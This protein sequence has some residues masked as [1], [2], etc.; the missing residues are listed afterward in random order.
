MLTVH[1]K[2]GRER[3]LENR[4]P[5][6]FDGAIA[7]VQ[8]EPQPGDLVDVVD[9]AGAFRGRGY[10]N[11]HSQ[12][13]VRILTW[14]RDEMIDAAFWRRRLAASIARRQMLPSLESCTAYRLVYA[15]SDGL[16]GLIVD[17]YGDWL[18][19]QSLTAG[20][21]R[22]KD[23]L[24]RLLVELLEPKG[25]Y[26]RSDADVRPREGLAD[27]VGVL[28]GEAPQSDPPGGASAP[29]RIGENGRRFIV[30]IAQGHKTGFYLDQRDNRERVARY[31]EGA[32]VLNAFAYTG[33]FGV[34]AGTAGASRVTNLDSSAEALALAA[35][36]MALNGIA[37]DR[38]ESIQGDAFAILRTM[39]DQ[40]RR[41]DVIV[42]DPPKFAFSR[43][44]VRSA[45][46][47]YKDI[48][49]QA[50]H[51]L[52]PGGILVTFSCSGAVDETLFQKV[53]FG[54]S[55]DAGRD[56]SILERLSQAS[57]HPVLLTFPEGA[58]LKGFVCQVR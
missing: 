35:E 21:E 40:A 15:E 19:L 10:Y 44:Q 32:E 37:A 8:G 1:L 48:N 51:L 49:L 6:I 50:M 56:V 26:E 29:V 43:A 12:I 9:S 20:I 25:V 13:T 24:A 33:G 42:L 31:C 22:W 53:I 52:R 47:G 58:Y 30:D 54:A 14:D 27:V 38:V 4:H 17:R 34:Y 36:N 41:F 5:W 16:P 57:D 23:R 11:S 3:A 39:R 28:A 2:K 45:T 18:V 46:R 55:L 7:R